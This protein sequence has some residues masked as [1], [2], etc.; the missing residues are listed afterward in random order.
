LIGGHGVR[1]LFGG[2]STLAVGLGLF[3]AGVF[4]LLNIVFD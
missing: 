1:Q 4:F 2:G 3:F